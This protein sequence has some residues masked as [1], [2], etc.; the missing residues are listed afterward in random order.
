MSARVQQAVLLL[1]VLY[2]SVHLVQHVVL[3]RQ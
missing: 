3:L 1:C 2:S